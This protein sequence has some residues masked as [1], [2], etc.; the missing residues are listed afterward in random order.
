VDALHHTLVGMFT[1]K[2][3]KTRLGIFM[4]AVRTSQ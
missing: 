1:N 4:A 3:V 2:T